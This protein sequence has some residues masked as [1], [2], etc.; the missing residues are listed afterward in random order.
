MDGRINRRFEAF[1][2]MLGGWRA[3]RHCLFWW[4][5]FFWLFLLVRLFFGLRVRVH[6]R[7][8]MPLDARVSV[9]IPV[10]RCFRSNRG[11]RIADELCGVTED[12]SEHTFHDLDFGARLGS[13]STYCVVA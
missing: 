8:E 7:R 1:P 11:R 12:L 3:R 13:G 2:E 10:L 9:A 5:F 6:T 4:A